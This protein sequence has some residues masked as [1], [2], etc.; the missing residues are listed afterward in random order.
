MDWWEKAYPGGPM[1]VPAAMFPRP[2]YPP[3]SSA[4]GKTPSSKGPDAEAYKRTVWRAGRWQGPASGFDRAFSNAFS[5][6]KSSNVG[7]TGIAGIQRQQKIDPTGWI[8]QATFNT[9]CSIRIPDGLPNAGQ[10]AMD[11]TAANLIAEAFGMFGGSA[12][13][14][15]P[16]DTK[17]SAQVRLEKAISYLGVKESPPNSNNTIFGSWYGVNYQPWCAIFVTYCDQLGGKPCKSFVRGSRYAYVPYVVSDA[18]NKQNWLS[19]PDTPK[20]G[21]LVCFDWARDGTFDHIGIF[22][23]WAGSS[24]SAFTSIE[25]NTSVGNDSDGGEVMRR[26]RDTRNQATVFVRVAEP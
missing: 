13:P 25:G 4:Q 2:L 23:A 16:P 1:V 24:P 26:S 11:V 5:H 18:R 7:E 22:E 15:D 19:V 8:G 12:T 20:P 21:D 10:M 3:D 6:G 14:D 9:L 17:S